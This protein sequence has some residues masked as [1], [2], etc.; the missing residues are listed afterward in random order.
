MTR[1]SI[2]ALGVTLMTVALPR[3][4]APGPGAAVIRLDP[5]LDAIISAGATLEVL[6]E[7]F[8]GFTEG[9]V[10]VR[11][12]TSGYVLFSDMGANKI[13]K[14]TTDGKFSVFLEPSGF[15]GSDFSKIRVINN[16][17]LDVAISGTNG[18]ALDREGRLVM[19]TH[20][21]RAIVRLEKDGKRTVLADRYEGKRLNGPN[22][23][24]VKSDGAIY[25]TDRGSG[26][27]GGQDSP[28]RE[29]KMLGVFRL[30]D[31][32]LTLLNTPGMEGANG[33]AFSPDEKILY[34]TD[35][36]KI[37]RWDVRP[38]GTVANGRVLFDT[39]SDKT[40]GGTDGMKVDRKG[41]IFTTGPGGVWI[42]TPDGTVLG[43]IRLPG[44]L[45]GATS[46]GAVTN[47]A[48]GDADG[49]SLYING[50]RGFY[51]IRLNAPAI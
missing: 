30:K 20:G 39:S 44:L 42:V 13:Y 25:F 36:G 28:L 22:D 15:T 40:R 2:A 8:F 27:A 12:G 51:R 10:F 46:E 41:N 32:T 5:R 29:L 45:P 4:Q 19:C 35:S 50:S 34:F 31:G 47:T 16:G 7:E 33:I 3:A 43:K 49:K 18:L 21:D 23:L 24:V 38:D 6:K 9:T 37:W 26:L 11:E 17:R 14:L 1:V 48:F